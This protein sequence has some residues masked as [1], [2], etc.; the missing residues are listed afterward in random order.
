V[1]IRQN[2]EKFPGLLQIVHPQAQEST[3]STLQV[4]MSLLREIKPRNARTARIVKARE[5]QV[6]EDRKRTLLLHGTKCPPTIRTVL[7]TI[8]SLT[9]PHSTHLNKKNENIHPFEDAS[10]LE[11]LAGKND[12]GLVVFG[13][14]SKKRPNSITILRVYNGKTLDM[15]EM[16][17]LPQP[18]A[19]EESN[20]QTLFQ[21]GVEMKPLILFAGSQW[22]DTSSSESAAIYQTLKS[23]LLDVFCGEE[24]SSID[25]AGMQYMLLIA[26]PDTP[27]TVRPLPGS[28]DPK[29]VIQL[30]WYKILTRKS[31]TKVPRVELQPEGPAFDFRVSRYKEADSTEMKD[32]LRKGRDPNTART[33][34][35]IE[36]D[37][38]GDKLGRVH[39]GKQDLS[40]LQTRKMKGLKRSRDEDDEDESAYPPG[41]DEEDDIDLEDGGMELDGSEEG[42]DVD[43]L[44]EQDADIFDDDNE[45]AENDLP[46]RQK[47]S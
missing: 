11:F 32:A 7:T 34:K 12:C 19:E 36:T 45:D 6:L 16:L 47:L 30:R 15:V 26:A 41:M 22:A 38:V 20:K 18:G 37:F 35:N 13:A 24:I 43:A 17:L 14:S 21:V 10:S 9:K 31:G 3:Q 5:P 40:E 42:S 23:L 25:V 44:L 8:H 28:E 46:K 4:N 27:S 29:P 1:I 33:K 2:F 39:L